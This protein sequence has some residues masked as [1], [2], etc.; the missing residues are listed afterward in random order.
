MRSGPIAKSER[1]FQRRKENEK[2]GFIEIQDPSDVALTFEL[3]FVRNMTSKSNLSVK[4][5]LR[6]GGN[7]LG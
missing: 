7:V 4:L 3:A 6:F 1:M 2:E 5:I